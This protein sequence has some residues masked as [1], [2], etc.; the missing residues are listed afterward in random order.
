MYS[1]MGRQLVETS[2][3]V[4]HASET[5]TVRHC[6]GFPDRLTSSR[7][8][9]FAS[10]RAGPVQHQPPE[11]DRTVASSP[12]GPPPAASHVFRILEPSLGL[13]FIVLGWRQP[14]PRAGHYG[15]SLHRPRVNGI[16]HVQD[17]SPPP[18]PPSSSSMAALLSASGTRHRGGIGIESA[19]TRVDRLVVHPT[20]PP[21]P[22]SHNGT[23]TGHTS[24]ST[25]RITSR[26]WTN[27]T[28][29]TPAFPAT[30]STTTTSSFFSA[31]PSNVRTPSV[32]PATPHRTQPQ[33]SLPMPAQTPRVSSTISSPPVD[34]SF[35]PATPAS[36]A[37]RPF[38]T[39]GSA[40]I[41]AHHPLQHSAF[42][43]A[44]RAVSVSPRPSK[45]SH[46]P[47]P[48]PPP[49][50]SFER[51]YGDQVG[52]H[53]SPCPSPRPT[54]PPPAN[55]VIADFRARLNRQPNAAQGARQ[56]HQSA[57]SWDTHRLPA[58]VSAPQRTSRYGH[59][60]PEEETNYEEPQ[61]VGS[62]VFAALSGHGTRTHNPPFDVEHVAR[63]AH[64]GPP[65]PPP[66]MG[67]PMHQAQ[68]MV[69][70][71]V[72]AMRNG[73]RLPVKPVSDLPPRFRGMF[74]FPY[75]N[76]IQTQCYDD[77]MHSDTN[78][79][80]SS[81]T[82]SGKTALLDLA[83]IRL[84]STHPTPR[85]VYLA[86]TK[87]LC[88]ERA[89]DWTRRLQPLGITVAELT[90]DTS[91][92]DARGAQ[93]AQ[94]LVITSEKYDAVTRRW[95]ESARTRQFVAQVGLVLLDEVHL[96]ASSRG[97]T[98]E[99]LVARM[100]VVSAELNTRIRYIALSATFPNIED[101][102]KWL[103]GGAKVFT[104]GDEYRPVRL[105]RLVLGYSTAHRSS[106]QFDK[107]LDAHLP[108]VI[109][110]HAAGK[111]A[112]V[113][114][115]TRKATEATAKLLVADGGGLVPGTNGHLFVRTSQH[116]R[117][118]V[119]AA[120]RVRNQAAREL[121]VHGV[122]FHHAG[123]EMADRQLIE[124]LFLAGQLLVL[125]TTS[126]L[127]VG[128]NLP[129]YLVVLKGTQSWTG[130]E[131]KEYAPMDVLQMLGRAGRPQ[132]ETSG[133]AIIMTTSN[134]VDEYESLVA[135]RTV[136]ESS[137]H[138]NLIE[139][140]NAEIAQGTITNEQLAVQW[141]ESTFL[142]VRL[143]AAPFYYANVVHGSDNLRQLV[144]STLQ[145][146]R[147]A[148]MVR[149]SQL[150]CTEYGKLMS[151]YCLSLQTMQALMAGGPSIP[152]QLYAM[153]LA[154]E[155][156][157]TYVKAGDKTMLADL[158]KMQGIKFRLPDK[159][160]Y[161]ST[162]DKVYLVVQA[163]LGSVQ[164]QGK[165]LDRLR[166]FVSCEQG[167]IWSALGRIA[168]AAV[169]LHVARRDT[170]P[171][172]ADRIRHAILLLQSVRTK[173]WF[174]STRL[175]R[176][177]DKLG[178][179]LTSTLA[180]AGITTF[181]ELASAPAWRLEQ[182]CRRNPPFGS[183]LVTAANQFPHLGV[184]GRLLQS[185]LLLSVNI[186]NAATCKKGPHGS[187]ASW[188]HVLVHDEVG[189]LFFMTGSHSTTWPRPSTR[190]ESRCHQVFIVCLRRCW[191]RIMLGWMAFASGSQDETSVSHA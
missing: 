18:P 103:G 51:P 97:S 40:V 148:E 49:S 162:A 179:V 68:G 78:L 1:R 111:P 24:S 116:A 105:E 139:H 108:N 61:A 53:H 175:L 44:S 29:S 177:V 87:A 56:S 112:L 176:Q 113:F 20:A 110:E 74:S 127:A 157:G 32:F 106:W 126:T 166:V 130:G 186:S 57:F 34:L 10:H 11:S 100:K 145:V 99:A 22:Y 178:P 154:S 58:A 41:G 141:L 80:T 63:P 93:S 169:E 144:A 9:H 26:F 146:L 184:L 96:L 92:F 91:L 30:P 31:R 16:D 94:L 17:V 90:G 23:A 153:A 109:R 174:D 50:A 76:Y 33:V 15:H 73:G 167:N 182:L 28:S 77:L 5:V 35:V 4:R 173:I 171:Y 189:K 183:G 6:H 81:P 52:P 120:Q 104:F 83:L 88:S 3:R 79:V 7:S 123:V 75:F 149:E 101:V 12:H 117:A 67:P 168:A 59:D 191:P 131:M 187:S 147:A 164:L 102:G 39:R 66:A 72:L 136:V 36:S 134:K 89:A 65:P 129:A 161:K 163:V 170:V 165:D 25:H 43:S 185:T 143:R 14:N 172:A 71:T 38:S 159:Y 27:P 140:L 98:L 122:A 8:F 119:E 158:N 69:P 156:S 42:A 54:L 128:V 150:E 85:A 114:C 124:Q 135:G 46:N 132:F 118:L 48:Q 84:W 13:P 64:C 151:R 62:N 137:L 21:L 155:F 181:A 142:Y 60:E 82:G 121:V 86:T 2:V 107:V 188:V 190:P 47:P 95:R 125:C 37:L 133:K 180:E 115:A 19:A 152:Q 70:A 45:H 138:S 55:D 160:K